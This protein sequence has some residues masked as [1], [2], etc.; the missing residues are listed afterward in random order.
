MNTI[1]ELKQQEK[2]KTMLK[3]KNKEKKIYKDKNASLQFEKQKLYRALLNR[4]REIERLNDI[5]NELEKDIELELMKTREPSEFNKGLHNAF[6]Y[7][8]GK[9]QKLKENNKNG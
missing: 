5:I 7:I 1:R 8:K 6:G 4:E 2:Y 3:R 9:L